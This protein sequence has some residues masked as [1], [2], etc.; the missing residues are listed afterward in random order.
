MK[1]VSFKTAKALKEAGY[2]QG[3]LPKILKEKSFPM[4]YNEDF[5]PNYVYFYAY[6]ITTFDTNLCVA[7]PTYLEVW[8][9]LWREK[10]IYLNTN[11]QRKGIVCVYWDDTIIHEVKDMRLTDPEEAIAS[12]IENMVDNDLIK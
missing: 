5:V 4:Y 1:R 2:P 6:Y 7:C 8:L 11:T 3:V 12:A 9:W 10:K